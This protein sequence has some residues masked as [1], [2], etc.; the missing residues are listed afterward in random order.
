MAEAALDRIELRHVANVEDGPDTELVVDRQGVLRLVD[1]QLVHVEGEWYILHLRAQ[2]PEE[3]VI[4]DLGHGSVVLLVVDEALLGRNCRNDSTVANI[5][6]CVLD[7]QLLTDVA[8]GFSV[9]RALGEADLVQIDDLQLHVP[10][11]LYVV[12][13]LHF[14]LVNFVLLG[15][16]SSLV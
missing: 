15:R 5:Q 6:V 8:P 11:R 9:D 14:L 10:R 2:V 12:K 7:G 1:L 4:A 13:C 16:W 3:G